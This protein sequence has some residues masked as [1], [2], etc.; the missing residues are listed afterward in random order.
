MSDEGLTRLEYLRLLRLGYIRNMNSSAM[1]K[2]LWE[3]LDA[4]EEI[5]REKAAEVARLAEIERIRIE[6]EKLQK[7]AEQYGAESSLHDHWISQ[8]Q[9]GKTAAAEAWAKKYGTELPVILEA[10]ETEEEMR[11]AI[12]K[13]RNVAEAKRKGPMRGNRSGG[14]RKKG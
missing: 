6:T 10:A 8:R 13:L 1:P 2:D 11:D 9:I 14:P 5:E 4:L 3:E 7:L 12:R